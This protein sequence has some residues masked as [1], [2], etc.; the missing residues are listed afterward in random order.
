MGSS[1]PEKHQQLAL[2]KLH[3]FQLLAETSKLKGPEIQQI[4]ESIN[5]VI[6]EESQGMQRKLNKSKSVKETVDLKA[7]TFL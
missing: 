7:R 3:G 1:D 2:A 6:E 4:I 5:E